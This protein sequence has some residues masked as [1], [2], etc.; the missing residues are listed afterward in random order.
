MA[1][2]IFSDVVGVLL[3]VVFAACGGLLL[4]GLS[5]APGVLVTLQLR[6]VNPCLPYVANTDEGLLCIVNGT[7]SPK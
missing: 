4:F 1:L 6:D 3:R 5:P 7:E 2:D